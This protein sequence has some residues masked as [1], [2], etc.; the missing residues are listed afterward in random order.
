M[1]INRISLTLKLLTIA[2]FILKKDIE[3]RL[4]SSRNSYLR[5]YDFI[6]V[7][8]GSAGGILAHRLA[9]NSHIKVLLLEAG[10][11]N[12]IPNDI[13]V[14]YLTLFNSEFDWN[15]TMANQFVGLAFVDQRI[16]ENRGHVLGGSS[17]TNAMIFNRGN[18]RDYDQ[19]ESKFG[20]IG[21]SY[22]DVLPYFKKYERNADPRIVA[23]GY[24]GTQG[25]IEVLF[26]QFFSIY[27]LKIIYN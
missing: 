15:Y 11:P 20:A 6:V 17:S 7:G 4:N 9:E 24:H 3:H 10:G 8:S 1:F 19:W 21:W 27:R 5:R 26:V 22:A 13:P 16:P 25:P 2:S 14:E 23:N 12:G 18:R